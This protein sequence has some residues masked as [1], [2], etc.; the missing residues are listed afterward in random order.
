MRVLTPG[1]GLGETPSS[2]L[3]VL[4]RAI[5]L[6]IPSVKVLPIDTGAQDAAPLPS[7]WSRNS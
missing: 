7:T 4:R 1:R 5:T 6:I 3:G 2:R